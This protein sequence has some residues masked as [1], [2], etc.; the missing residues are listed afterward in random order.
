MNHIAIAPSSLPVSL[1]ALL[2]FTLVGKNEHLSDHTR[3]EKKSGEPQSNEDSEARSSTHASYSHK[4]PA[5][6]QSPEN[7]G[8]LLITPIYYK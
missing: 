5:D 6:S 8:W 7:Q 3:Y 4:P 1:S 2:N